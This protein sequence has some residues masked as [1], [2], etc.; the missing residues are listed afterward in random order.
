MQ[1]NQKLVLYTL[2]L[3]YSGIIVV[4]HAA[5]AHSQVLHF[6]SFLL[7]GAVSDGGRIAVIVLLVAVAAVV[8]LT[9]IVTVCIMILR[10]KYNRWEK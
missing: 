6:S 2:Q 5:V 8:I 7:S 3:V 10:Y 4:L 9:S 1:H